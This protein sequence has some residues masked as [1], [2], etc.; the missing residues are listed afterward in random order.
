M[1]AALEIRIRSVY[2]YG[3]TWDREDSM[4]DS[5]EHVA[6]LQ[7]FAESCCDALPLQVAAKRWGLVDELAVTHRNGPDFDTWLSMRNGEKN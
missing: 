4:L 1:D 6:R 3:N 2:P 5:K 7:S